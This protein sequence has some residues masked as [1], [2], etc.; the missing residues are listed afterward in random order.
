[1]S[2]PYAAFAERN[3]R[4]YAAGFFI[5]VVG[6]QMLNVGL[7]WEIYVRTH[8][9]TALGLIGLLE[10]LPVIALALP[11]GHVADRYNRKRV[12]LAISFVLLAAVAYRHVPR[13]D[14]TVTFRSLAA[15]FKFVRDT[16][17]ILATITLDLFAVLLGGA[18]ALLPMFARDILNVGPTGLGWLR[19]APSLGAL[20]VAVFLAHRPPMRR[21]GQALLWAVTG[22]GAATIGFGLSRDFTL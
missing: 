9:A 2:T 15:G 4:F 19:A 5:S 10:A 11:A 1:M 22:F 17:I 3:Y 21:P 18:T 14:E 16:K 8:S 7:G 13:A 20:L 6:G 12:M